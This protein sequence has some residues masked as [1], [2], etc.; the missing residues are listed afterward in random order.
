[1]RWP[2]SSAEEN[3]DGSNKSWLPSLPTQP[4]DQKPP[5]NWTNTLN[6]TAWTSPEVLLPTFLLTTASLFGFK[7]YTLYLRRIPQATYI[8]PDAMGKRSIFGYVTAVGD[9][10]TFRLY[11]TPGGRLLGWGWLPGRR[12][13]AF[14]K[15]DLKD[16]TIQ[17]RVAG[18]DAP[19]LA[20]FGKPAQVYGKEALEGLRGLIRGRFVRAKLYR[21]DQY[22]RVVGSVTV[23]KWGVWPR[24]VGLD[25]L[26]LGHA[27]VY[28]AKFGSEFGGMEEKYRAAER[29]AKGH[30]VGLWKGQGAPG[31]RTWWQK[32]FMSNKTKAAF[33]TPRQ[34]KDRTKEM[35]EG[36]A[37]S[38]KS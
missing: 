25:M 23:M 36:K 22:Q 6:K 5:I 16:Q 32:L 21:Q 7:F 3:D 14:T 4:E 1:M 8:T 2:W 29:K 30:G 34:F 20:H 18:I 26:R 17:V 19:E 27:T 37:G 11:H 33:E 15:K 35:E 38:K 31:L 9:G 10:D 13:A 24:D 28:E 12:V